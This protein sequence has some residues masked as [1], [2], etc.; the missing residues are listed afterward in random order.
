MRILVTNDD[1]IEAPGLW[2]VAKELQKVGQ[3]TVVA[4]Q[5]EQSGV[6]SSVNL[7]QAVKVSKVKLQL[8]DVE[9]YSVEGTPADCVIIAIN[10][11][12][13][14]EINVVVSGINRGPNIGHDIFVSG[15]VGAALQGYLHGIPSLAISLNAYEDLH[16]ELAAKLA[17]LLVA[18]LQQGILPH[19][20]L[21]NVN[22]PNLPPGEIGGIEITTLSRRSYSDTVQQVEG[23]HYR[24]IRAMEVNSE[25]SGSDIWALQRNKISITPLSFD[26]GNSSTSSLNHRLQEL[27]SLFYQRF[28]HTVD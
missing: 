2:A 27:A 20:L 19:E 4:P 16:F 26:L 7:R 3:V 21:L 18:E 25:H 17:T 9:A 15:T 12:F 10:S 22:L 6:G 8:K 14:G 11:L 23:G 13:P 5:W 28:Y 24:I 1:G